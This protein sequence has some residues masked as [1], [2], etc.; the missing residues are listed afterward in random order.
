MD[1][2]E[3][4]GQPLRQRAA[5]RRCD[6]VLEAAVVALAGRQAEPIEDA[7]HGDELAREAGEHGE[8]G[9]PLASRVVA[10]ADQALEAAEH[11]GAVAFG[12]GVEEL[13]GIFLAAIL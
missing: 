2:G 8:E 12:K 3:R 5:E 4:V 11:L 7:P 6:A 10:A 9:E 1:A 13:P